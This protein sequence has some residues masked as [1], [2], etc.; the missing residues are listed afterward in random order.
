MVPSQ[1][2]GGAFWTCFIKVESFPELKAN[3]M[4]KQRGFTKEFEDEAVRLVA[5]SGWT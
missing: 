1:I 5:S 3:S 4:T 2:T